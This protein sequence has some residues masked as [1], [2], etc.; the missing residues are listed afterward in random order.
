MQ[1]EKNVG[2]EIDLNTPTPSHNRN[3]SIES[4][5]NRIIATN[6]HFIDSK[7]FY[8]AKKNETK[9]NTCIGYWS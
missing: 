6:A 4:V 3:F 7:N 8:G 5:L 9:Q 1:R 2:I